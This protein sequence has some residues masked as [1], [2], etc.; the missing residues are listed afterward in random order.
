MRTSVLVVLIC[1]ATASSPLHGAGPYEPTKNP[2]QDDDRAVLALSQSAELAS[3]MAG[4]AEAGSI[5]C[6]HFFIHCSCTG[7]F[8]CAWLAWFCGE[9]GG[10]QGFDGDCFLP[11]SVPGADVA[12]KDLKLRAR[13][14][15]AKATCE[16]IFCSCTGPSNSSDCNRI[17]GCIDDILCIGDSCGCIGGHVD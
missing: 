3:R 12:L 16:G 10:I 2:R 15:S 9:A 5:A 14:G 1:L 8:H 13:S 17:K 4:V 11:R 7:A 6:D